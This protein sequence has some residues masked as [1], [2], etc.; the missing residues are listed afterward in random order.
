MMRVALAAFCLCLSACTSWKPVERPI[1]ATQQ[2]PASVLVLPRVGDPVLLHQPAVVGDSI[3]GVAAGVR[4]SF[5]INDVSRIRQR[6]ADPPKPLR[7]T[8]SV[9]GEIA[10]AVGVAFFEL[11]AFLSN[12]NF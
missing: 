6:Q 11:V 3:I 1:L 2:N 9:A 10:V 4:R 5:A 7:A 12:L 8:A